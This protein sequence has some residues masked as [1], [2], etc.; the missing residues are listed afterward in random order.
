MNDPDDIRT[1]LLARFPVF[2]QLTPAHLCALLAASPALR[3]PAGSVL[4]EAGM[5]CEGFPLVLDGS[6]RV[7]MASAGG[8][9]IVLYRVSP[10]EG[11]VLSGGCL[12]GQ[13]D[14]TARGVAET[15]L[16]LMR[17]APA[18]FEDLLLRCA[19]F[20]RFV[21]DMFGARLAEVMALV[22]EVAFRKLDTRLARLLVQRGPVIGATH[23]DLADELGSVRVFVSR[24]LRSFEER[25]WVRLERERVNVLDPKALLEFA[26]G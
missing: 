8:R 3:V 17:I 24:L 15:E 7:S 19:P 20:R 12:L 11:C 6:V 5:P 23:Q 13:R 26:R 10:G 2:A 22:E 18:P 16:T 1:R 9:E 14:Y 25:G 21:F 4:F